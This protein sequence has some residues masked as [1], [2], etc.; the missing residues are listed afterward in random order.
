MFLWY[1]LERQFRLSLQRIWTIVE[2]S[3]PPRIEPFYRLLSPTTERSR[4]SNLFVFIL[5]GEGGLT[6]AWVAHL[7]TMC[8]HYKNFFIYS[9]CSQPSSHII[10]T[11]MDEPKEARCSEAPHDRFIVVVGKCLLC[12]RR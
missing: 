4:L 12:P 9:S 6:Y 3:S 7:A 8:N 2:R 1:T 11:E 5:I 10:R